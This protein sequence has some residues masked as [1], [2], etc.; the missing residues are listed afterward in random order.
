[1]VELEFKPNLGPSDSATH[2]LA[3]QTR[4]VPAEAPRHGSIKA[5]GTDPTVGSGRP[6]LGKHQSQLA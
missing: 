4:G 1:M 3:R 6:S 2:I 5:R